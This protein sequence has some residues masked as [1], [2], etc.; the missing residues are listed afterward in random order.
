MEE[1]IVYVW[2]QVNHHFGTV[3]KI[4]YYDLRRFCSAAK[5]G[6]VHQNNTDSFWIYIW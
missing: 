2:L 1:I 6:T 3:K 5:Q 4:V